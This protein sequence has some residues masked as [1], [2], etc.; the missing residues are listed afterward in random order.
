[1]DST[2]VRVR[3]RPV[4]LGWCI[5][6]NNWDDLRRALRLTH[7]FWGG[8]F[9]PIIPVAS[10]GADELVRRFRVDVLVDISDDAQIKAFM[11]KFKHL[12]WPLLEPA[13]FSGSADD[14]DPNFLDISH[15]LLKIAD[16]RRV[17]EYVLVEDTPPP[18]PENNRFAYVHWQ[19]DDPLRDVLLAT[20]GS[21]PS[22][23]EISRDYGRFILESIRPSYYWTK[24]EQPIPA[25]LLEKLTPSEISALDL[26]WDR[27]PH[28]P[29]V[30]FYAGKADD[31]EDIVNYWNLAAAGLNL[32]FLDPAHSQ[33]LALLRDAQSEFI[34]KR[35]TT[36][37]RTNEISV[38]SRSHDIVKQLEFPVTSIESYHALDGINIVRGSLRPALQYFSQKMVLATMSARQ[39]RPILTFQ[40]PKKPFEIEDEWKCRD[41]HF[42]VAVKNTFEEAD[43][44]NTFWTPDVP[45]LNPWFGRNFVLGNRA[46]RAETDGIGVIRSITDESFELGAIPKHELAK[47]LFELAGISAHPSLPGRIASRLISQLGGLQ[48]CRVLKVAGVRSLIRRHSPLQEFDWSTAINTIARADPTTGQPAFSAYKDLFIGQRDPTISKFEPEH[49]FQYLLDKGVFRVGLTPVCPVCNLSFWV[50]LDDLSTEMNCELCNNRF[51]ITGQL[52]PHPWKYRKS[53]LFGKENNQEGSIPVALTLQQLDTTVNRSYE[54][55]LLLTNMILTSSESKIR[56]CETDIFVAIPR[57]DKIQVA[58]GEC[59]DAGGRIEL[60]DARKLAAVADAFPRSKFESYI[61]FSKTAPFSLDEIENCRAAQCTSGALRVIM[62]SNRELEPY[63][64]YEKTSQ[65]FE[66]RSSAGSLETMARITHDVFFAPK[67]KTS[68]VGS[69]LSLL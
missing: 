13:L 51:N 14:N 54:G 41:Q 30:G 57:R 23:K 37:Q 32:L 15:I 66:I 40:L 43:S 35:Q 28:D 12:P 68:Q 5:R 36:T 48:G 20:F 42:V 2:N 8:K 21:Y 18:S 22:I 39:G 56:S 60:D 44:S 3:Y 31:F 9:N 59:K 52:K 24:P 58:L 53:G 26:N 7:I 67:P 46:V 10:S 1:M 55:S 63:F 19:D 25:Y 50:N 4:R 33:R 49:A 29:S 11:D 61:V 62:L 6:D 69:D 45:E 64:A 47:K 17:P 34:G 16:D 65:E 27:K 38:W